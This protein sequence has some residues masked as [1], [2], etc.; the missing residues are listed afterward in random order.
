MT[1]TARQLTG[2]VVYVRIP[3]DVKAEADRVCD[4]RGVSLAKLVSRAVEAYLVGLGWEH[5][6]AEP[7]P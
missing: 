3:R 1:V 2:S 5:E 4:E 6:R 7:L